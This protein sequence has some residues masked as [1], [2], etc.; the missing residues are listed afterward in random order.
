MFNARE[1][2]PFGKPVF[3][4]EYVKEHGRDER[5][6]GVRCYCEDCKEPV[7]TYVSEAYPERNHFA[8][9]P[10]KA[11]TP[12]CRARMGEE[13]PWRGYFNNS[14]RRKENAD[15]IRT[16]LA[17]PRKLNALLVATNAMLRIS[18]V[19]PIDLKE[20]SRYIQRA[21]ELKLLEHSKVK[22]W[23]IPFLVLSVGTFSSGED[24]IRFH[25]DRHPRSRQWV[26]MSARVSPN[27]QVSDE[28]DFRVDRET[29]VRLCGVKRS[30]NES[31]LGRS[32]I[33]SRLR[34]R[35]RKNE[36]S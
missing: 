11:D 18:K 24:K 20:F 13:D 31:G 23:T 19:R 33:G 7:H 4:T 34:S 9:F 6:D 25:F 14:E 32:A 27:G 28:E 15:K 36:P 12:A 10:T 21:E 8:H 1:E 17:E 30:S 35:K 26:L 5:A 2:S 29:I 3:I 16:D 22:T